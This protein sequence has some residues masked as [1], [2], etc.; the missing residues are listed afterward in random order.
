MSIITLNGFERDEQKKILMLIS[1]H[2][3]Y[4]LNKV[5]HWFITGNPLLGYVP[6]LGMIQSGKTTKLLHA[7]QSMLD[8]NYR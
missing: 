1:E 7:V 4:D 5:I 3:N 6:P 8:G 2:F